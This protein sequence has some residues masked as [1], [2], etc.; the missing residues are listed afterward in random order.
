MTFMRA[1]LTL[2]A[3]TISNGERKCPDTATRAS[4]GHLWN[5]SM[6]QPDTRPGNLRD[7]LRNFSPTCIYNKDSEDRKD[8]KR[9]GIATIRRINMKNNHHFIGNC[10]ES[11]SEF[12][13]LVTTFFMWLFLYKLLT[14]LFCITLLF[15]I[16]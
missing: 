1:V 11:I 2:S 9:L 12:E 13:F 8:K 6:V 4:L 16:S 5:Q 3:A 10:F 14:V 7:R 15:I